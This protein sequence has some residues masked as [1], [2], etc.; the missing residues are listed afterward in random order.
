[1][2]TKNVTI[3]VVGN[4]DEDIKTFK[5]P[6]NFIT[7]YKK[8]LYIATFTV[9]GFF[10]LLALFFAY[11]MKVSIDKNGLTS[12]LTSVNEKLSTYE[13][14]QIHEKL[15][16]IDQ[17][18]SL[19]DGYLQK[20]GVLETKDAGG[21][22]SVTDHVSNIE[23]IDY[24]E[25]QSI[26]FFNTLKEIPVGYQY[27]GVKSSDYGYRRNPF[28]GFSGEFH[29]GVDLKG[30]VGDPIYATGDGIINRCDQYGGYGNAVLIDHTGGY[31]SL[32]GH[33]TKV[34]VTQGQQVKAGDVIGFLGST[35]RST[36]P[37][38]HYEIRKD[39]VDIS[40]EAFL[41]VF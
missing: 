15:S 21:E 10:L 32:Y 19:I 39:G 30:I 6:K 17:N 18:L 31:Q 16:R 7:N 38:V 28:G 12:Q 35:G 26:V 8:Y 24:F 25:K 1:M 22:P 27:Y 3:L 11:T 9:G 34:N 23:K 4:D 14:R 20:R 36:G 41:K 2:D 40:P 37:H 33:L 13:D 5:I 29:P